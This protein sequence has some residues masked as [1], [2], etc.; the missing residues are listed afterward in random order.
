MTLTITCTTSRVP[1]TVF[2][3]FAALF[4][5]SMATL[6]SARNAPTVA[7][8]NYSNPQLAYDDNS[9]SF[10]E[11]IAND[12]NDCQEVWSGFAPG[13]GTNYLNVTSSASTTGDHY[14]VLLEYSLDGGS[15][16]PYLIYSLH[17][18]ATRSKR[19][20]S[21]LLPTGQNLTQVQVQG[22]CGGYGAGGSD[23]R[24]YEIWISSTPGEQMTR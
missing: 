13:S 17:F 20:D 10:A 24:V 3:A 12:F 2:R 18:T 6:A 14:S 11:G 16:W 5:L 9:G 4:L 22:L 19:T 23:H 21:L 1:Q 15:T 8:G 7:N